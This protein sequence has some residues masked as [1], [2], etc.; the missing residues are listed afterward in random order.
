[1]EFFINQNSTLPILKMEPVID[2]KSDSYKN[3]IEIPEL[4]SYVKDEDK[5]WFKTQGIAIFGNTL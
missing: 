2:G 1:M 5:Y 3:I 4:K